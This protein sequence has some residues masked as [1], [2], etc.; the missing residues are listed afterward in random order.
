MQLDSADGVAAATGQPGLADAGPAAV[1]PHVVETVPASPLQPL[2]AAEA[3][4]AQPPVQLQDVQALLSEFKQDI[5]Q[6]LPT[7]RTGRGAASRLRV[8]TQRQQPLGPVP[9]AS[10]SGAVVAMAAFDR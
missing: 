10:A 9:R 3:P 4:A 8:A 6:L 7:L 5:L 1:Q 2:V